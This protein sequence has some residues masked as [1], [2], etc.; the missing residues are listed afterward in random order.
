MWAKAI[1]DT[2]STTTCVTQ[3]IVHCLEL[4]SVSEADMTTPSGTMSCLLYAI[5]LYLPDDICIHDITVAETLPTGCDIIIGMDIIG[6]G[7]FA[8]SN[9]NGKTAFTFRMPS[10]HKFDFTKRTYT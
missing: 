5:N 9:L 2:G 1:W 3:K 4:H 8:V 10:L 6:Q 7:D